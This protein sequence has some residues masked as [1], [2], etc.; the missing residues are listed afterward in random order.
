MKTLAATRN[1]VRADEVIGNKVLSMQKEDLGKIYQLVLDKLTGEVKY[2]VL[3]SGSFLGL[4]GKFFALP[5]NSISYDCVQEAFILKLN[6]PKKTFE[7]A[8]GFDKD[9]WPEFSD[10]VWNNANTS[11]YSNL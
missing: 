9:H 4:G 10:D 2:I 8:P 1:I 7:K 5:W 6:I 3:E 11:F